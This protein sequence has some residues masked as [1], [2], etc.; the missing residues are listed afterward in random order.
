MPYYDGPAIRDIHLGGAPAYTWHLSVVNSG[1]PRGE[2]LA[3]AGRDG[4]WL[5]AAELGGVAWQR[6]DLTAGQWLISTAPLGGGGE[7]ATMS[8]FFGAPGARPIAGDFNGDGVD[9]VG[10]YVAGEWFI[11]LNGN[12]RWDA[13]DLWARLGD[14]DDLPVVGDWDGDGK[15][16]IGIFGPAW[17]GDSRA[18]AHE[19]GLPDPDNALTGFEKNVPPTPEEATDGARLLKRSAAG[20]MRADL[21]DHVFEYGQ[22]GDTP[23][24]GDFNGDG[25][26]SIGVFQAGEWA[27]DVDGDG[28]WSDADIALTFGREGDIPLVGDFNGDGVADVGV[29]RS[30]K[31]LLD[32][33]GNREL[34]AADQ[35]FELGG[36]GASPVVGDF[37]G[38]GVDEPAVYHPNIA[39]P[40]PRA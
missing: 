17:E 29:F 16:D 14:K 18:I 23:V 39:A 2:G 3:D 5:T 35:V 11:D 7:G 21:I 10:V 34:D 8:H 25:I 6:L 22:A 15:D 37:N 1:E 9:E 31:F 26:P 12:G 36:A 4:V 32:T 40:P 33:N 28:R 38:D 30:G 24:T 13:G 20:A 27:L 19:P